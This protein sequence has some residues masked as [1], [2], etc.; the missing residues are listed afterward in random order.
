MMREGFSRAVTME[1]SDKEPA[2]WTWV[3]SHGPGREGLSHLPLVASHPHSCP[4]PRPSLYV[5]SPKRKIPTWRIASL[6]VR[7]CKSPFRPELAEGVPQVF[8]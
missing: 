2:A 8:L 3:S 1:L 4:Y 7:A 6:Q 5:P